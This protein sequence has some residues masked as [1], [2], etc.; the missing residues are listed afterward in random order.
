M[1]KLPREHREFLKDLKKRRSRMIIFE[2]EWEIAMNGGIGCCRS[3]TVSLDGNRQAVAAFWRHGNS[4]WFDSR[5]DDPRVSVP[6]DEVRTAHDAG[7]PYSV[8]QIGIA[9]FARGEGRP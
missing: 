3:E 2:R 6:F 9:T 7:Q 8:P 5:V 4:M 1:T